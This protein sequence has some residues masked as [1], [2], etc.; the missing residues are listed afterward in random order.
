M[1]CFAVRFVIPLHERWQNN[2]SLETRVLHVL[3]HANAELDGTTTL[4]KVKQYIVRVCDEDLIPVLRDLPIPFRVLS[5]D[6]LRTGENLYTY[7]NHHVPPFVPLLQRIYW[8]AKS[9][10]RWDIPVPGTISNEPHK[11]K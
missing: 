4:E 7:R 2:A 3:K 5:I 8:L 10:E 6:I 11:T 1:V 9:T